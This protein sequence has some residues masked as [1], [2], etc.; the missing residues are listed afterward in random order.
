MTTN[1]TKITKA[2]GTSYTPISLGATLYDDSIV[3]YDS[4]VTPY[5]GQFNTYTTVAKASGTSYTKI[6][7][8]T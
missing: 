4:S 6:P 7:K 8:A 3:I 2:S 5:D 1:Y